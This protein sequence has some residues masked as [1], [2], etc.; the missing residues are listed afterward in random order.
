MPSA[1][2]TLINIPDGAFHHIEHNFR[3]PRSI[4]LSSL[5]N[6]LT[7]YE[8]TL[9]ALQSLR[10]DYI[11]AQNSSKNNQLI[12]E[13]KTL[14]HSAN[15]H[16]DACFQ[17]IKSTLPSSAAKS[18]QNEAFLDQAKPDG[19]KEFKNS[20]EEYRSKRIGKIVNMLKHRQ[21]EINFFYFHA[22]GD[23]RPGYYIVD[24]HD[25]KTIGPAPS[26]HAGGNTAFSCYRDLLLH[27]WWLHR[28]GDLLSKYLS[29]FIPST[30]P[31]TFTPLL[32]TSERWG[33]VIKNLSNLTPAP[34]PDE[35]RLPIPRLN[36]HQDMK[37]FTMQFPGR[38][39]FHFPNKVIAS[40]QIR[41]E[42]DHP[43][44]KLP[45]FGRDKK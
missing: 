45:Y 43:T 34:F 37:K 42:A 38:M 5:N 2:D 22:P 1:W 24:I 23:F 41:V 10:L 8:K 16:F 35:I 20:I 7:S 25:H 12:H 9:D 28:I 39:I 26:V 44:N 18:Q 36:C 11:Y 19:W 3:H 32:E 21:A 29:K 4:Y 40:S 13:Y 14:L 27:F 17:I 33:K 15:E 6:I 31:A 30:Q